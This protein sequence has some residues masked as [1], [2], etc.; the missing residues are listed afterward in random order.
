MASCLTRDFAGF[1]APYLDLK[2]PGAGSNR[3]KMASDGIERVVVHRGDP[4]RGTRPARHRSTRHNQTQS[5]PGRKHT[6]PLPAELC[7]DRFGRPCFTQQADSPCY[8]IRDRGACPLGQL[9]DGWKRGVR[10]G[11]NLEKPG[12]AFRS[13][14]ILERHGVH[15]NP[16]PSHCHPAASSQKVAHNKT[17]LRV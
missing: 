15:C 13:G 7:T 8:S 2:T 16:Y 5:A 4:D 1:C 12:V 10:S 14:S 3:P 11:R 17:L 9:S 6:A